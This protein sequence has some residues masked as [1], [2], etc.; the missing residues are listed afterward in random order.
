MINIHAIYCVLL[1]L[2][3]TLQHVDSALESVKEEDSKHNRRTILIMSFKLA[4]F[5]DFTYSAM[6]CDQN[7]IFWRAGTDENICN[8]FEHYTFEEPVDLDTHFEEINKRLEHFDFMVAVASKGLS[9]GSL[10]KQV[11]NGVRFAL[12]FKNDKERTSRQA[13][14]FMNVFK[15]KTLFRML[16]VSEMDIVKSQAK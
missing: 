11:F 14:F 4:A 9:S 6:V 2:K 15:E 8:M 13:K 12:K 1:S 3:K 16:K 5:F 7:K 10:F